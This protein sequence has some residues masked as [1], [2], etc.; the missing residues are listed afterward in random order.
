MT[1]SFLDT[2]VLSEHMRTFDQVGTST[3]EFPPIWSSPDAEGGRS[4][5][6]RTTST[7]FAANLERSFSKVGLDLIP[8]SG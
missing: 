3:V 8:G 7:N 2:T 4:L 5:E 1:P 6:A